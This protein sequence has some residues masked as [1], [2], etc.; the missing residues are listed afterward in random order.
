M[1]KSVL[2]FSKL[3]TE[4]NQVSFM[5][6]YAYLHGYSQIRDM[7]GGTMWPEMKFVQKNIATAVFEAK[8]DA[9]NT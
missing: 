4:K 1:V 6:P 2:P 5:G 3:T 7:G 9:K 8:N